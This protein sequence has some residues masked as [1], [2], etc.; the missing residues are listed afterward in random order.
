MEVT[1]KD[2]QSLLD[3]AVQYLG[4]IEG[5]FALAERNNIS[6]TERLHNGCEIECDEADVVNLKVREE[7]AI[8]GIIPATEIEPQ[9]M[10]ILCV[11]EEPKREEG[12]VSIV[13]NKVD[14]I[15]TELKSGRE[16]KSESGL[17]LTKIFDKPFNSEFA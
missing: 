16:W 13:V 7:Y 5:I 3:I 2:R 11:G 4:S 1:V 17:S 8:R 9:A 14:E 6:I 10:H 15:L 12:D